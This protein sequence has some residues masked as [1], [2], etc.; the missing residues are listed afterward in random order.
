MP[1][2]RNTAPRRPRTRSKRERAASTGPPLA[3][4]AEASAIR[5][6]IVMEVL[7]RALE[8][9]RAGRSIV[10]LEIGEPD[11][12]TPPRIVRA[13]EEALRRGDT[14]YTDSR[15]TASLRAAIARHYETAYGASVSPDRVIVTMGTSPALL[16]V[17]SLLIEEPGDEIIVGDPGYPCYPNFIRHLRGVP[18]R[19]ATGEETGFQ[20]DPAAVRRAIG[21][22]TKGIIV[23]SPSNPAGTL[24]P[25]GDLAAL[26]DLGIPA[27]SDE[28]Y[29]GLV[30]GE[31][32]RSAL[33]F[34]PDAFVLNGF[35]KRYAMT[36]WRL[37]WVV[38]PACH[39]RRLQILQQNLFIC[40]SSFAQQAGIAALSETHPE[41]EEMRRT[42]D[43]RRRYLLAELPRLGLRSAVEPRGAFYFLVNARHIDG[44]SLRLAFDMLEC[45]GVAV[46]PGI[47]FGEGGEGYLRISYANS[48]ERIAEGVRRLET[49][50]ND[51]AR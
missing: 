51:R 22:R 6:F 10:H 48:I 26:C 9:A 34:A 24:V 18:R 3:G 27:I 36:G 39:I 29:H 5:P 47:D 21:P 7:E 43:A 25:P 46:A 16:L 50:L 12:P 1:A 44:D 30:Y 45:S 42:Y 32:A 49:Y 11:F 15:G 31:R 8:R 37:G 20:L 19:V 28:I 41:I 23:N 2:K 14:H 17:L 38:A 4:R 13:A 35:S 33:E 40:A